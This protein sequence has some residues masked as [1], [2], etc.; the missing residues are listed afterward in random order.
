MPEFET[1]VDVDV[2]DFWYECSTREKEEL[3][4]M[5]EE[6]GWVRRTIPKGNDPLQQ[7]P[8]IM[9]LEWLDMCNKLSELRLNMSRE[10]EDLIKEILK[11]Y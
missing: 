5:L 9:E 11:K 4:D 2:D 3:I 7:L 8:S 10:D 1:Y 6:D